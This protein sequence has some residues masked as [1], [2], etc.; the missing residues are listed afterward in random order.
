MMTISI[1]TVERN[2]EVYFGCPAEPDHH[3][4]NAMYQLTCDKQAI[5]YYQHKLRINLNWYRRECKVEVWSVS[6]LSWNEVVMVLMSD[7]VWKIPPRVRDVDR[8]NKH[9]EAI[10]DILR[11]VEHEAI[12]RA[13][14]V[15]QGA[16]V[17]IWRDSQ[18]SQK[19][20]C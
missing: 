20:S 8:N 3:K 16:K 4:L 5:A 2:P 15:L 13:S 1:T 14:W 19:V 18:D 17:N 6:S 7:D 11:T 9:R 12:N 10:S